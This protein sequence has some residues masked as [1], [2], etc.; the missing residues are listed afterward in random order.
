MPSAILAERAPERGASLAA[1]LKPAAL[2]R[3]GRRWVRRLVRRALIRHVQ[4]RP[5]DGERE[6]VTILLASAWGMGGTIRAVMHAAD[7]LVQR[8]DVE[9]V[10]LIRA[11][12]RPFFDFPPGV[13]VTP[14]D[15]RRP[16]AT[17]HGLRLLRRV[18]RGRPSLLM[19]R[20]DRFFPESSLWTDIRLIRLLRGR[21]GVLMSTRPGL[22][23]LAADL[24]PPGLITVGQEHIHLRAHNPRL[25]RA[26][27]RRY[28]RLDALVVLTE[29]DLRRYEKRL[30]RHIRLERIPNIVPVADAAPPPPLESPLVLAAGRLSRQKG[31][32]LLIRAFEQVV[33][34]HPEW[35]LRICGDGGQ[36]PVLQ[37]QIDAAGLDGVVELAEPARD[38][39]REMR[40]ASIFALSSRFEG[41]PVV[42]LEAMSV[43]MAV[44]SFNCPTGPS[45]VIEDH[46]NG[47]LL[48]ARD[49]DAL[50]R[51]ICELID[52]ANLRRRLGTAARV[53]ARRF[54]RDEVGPMWESLLQELNR[55]R[56]SHSAARARAPG[57]TP[58]AT[59]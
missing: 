53:S 35:R 20:E 48:P 2:R 10:S 50:A 6:T 33:R 55:E 4:A 8:H 40:S 15:D 37:H 23:L 29:R 52:D 7:Y 54:S 31:F 1:V 41:F 38:L 11:V 32:D 44:V 26:M 47:I 21:S 19:H 59:A 30:G 12:E 46:R 43:G 18:L 17:P 16:G 14:L 49:V 42:L 58:P 57:S 56:R 13:R 51:G 39:E 34:E 3:R 45:D 24:S 27:L 28:R 22:N 5:R 25:R 36:R 9:I